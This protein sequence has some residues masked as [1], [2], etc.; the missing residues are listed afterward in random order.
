MNKDDHFKE[1]EQILKDIYP[2]LPL[3][4]N[5]AGVYTIKDLAIEFNRE[6]ENQLNKPT[7]PGISKNWYTIFLDT[8]DIIKIDEK[9]YLEKVYNNIHPEHRGLRESLKNAINEQSKR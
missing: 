9:G 7:L 1:L 3:E 5:K 2:L 8:L 4:G 6:V